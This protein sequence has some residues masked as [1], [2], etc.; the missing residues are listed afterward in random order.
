MTGV[1]AHTLRIWEKRYQS[2]IPHRTDTNIRYYDNEQLRK[3]LNVSTLLQHGYKI[4]SLMSMS[5]DK[6]NGLILSLSSEQKTDDLA[7]VHINK[8]VSAMLAFDE[9]S[10]DKTC[11]NVIIRYGLYEAMVRVIYPF[12]RKTG[13]L[14]STRNVAPAQEHFASNIIKR[15]IQSAID[16]IKVPVGAEKKFVLFLPPGELHETGLLLS[17]YLIRNSGACSIYLGQDVPYESLKMSLEL[18]KVSHLLTFVP[19]NNRMHEHLERISAIAA[20]N[21]KPLVLVVTDAVTKE[22]YKHISFLASPDD[23]LKFL[24]KQSD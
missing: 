3:L 6:M 14:W 12:L 7:D 24:A 2:L 20:K 8:L 13:V 11:S 4:S 9:A 5:D 10:F 19:S 17:D 16:G 23:L 15:K 22:R 18:N 1:K 21:G